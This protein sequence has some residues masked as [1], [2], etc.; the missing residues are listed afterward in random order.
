M[1]IDAGMLNTAGPYENAIHYLVRTIWQKEISKGVQRKSNSPS[2]NVRATFCRH[3]FA[4]KPESV[5]VEGSGIVKPN[6]WRGFGFPRQLSISHHFPPR[7]FLRRA[8]PAF[9]LSYPLPDIPATL[10]SRRYIFHNMFKTLSQSIL[11]CRFPGPCPRV[12]PKTLI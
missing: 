9:P 11:Y 5:S 8:S 2:W 4:R 3:L 6:S 10:N 7:A 12:T 1:F